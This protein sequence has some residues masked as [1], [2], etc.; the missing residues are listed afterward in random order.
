MPLAEEHAGHRTNP[1][2]DGNLKVEE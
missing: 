1:D 2:V